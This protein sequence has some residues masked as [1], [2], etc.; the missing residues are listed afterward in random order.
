MDCTRQAPSARYEVP[1]KNTE[2]V[3]CPFSLG[4]SHPGSWHGSSTLQEDPL[5]TEPPG[6][7]Y[8]YSRSSLV[9]HFMLSTLFSVYTSILTS[10]SRQ[11]FFPPCIHMC[12]L[13]TFE[14]YFCFVFRPSILLLVRIY[15][16]EN[17]LKVILDIYLKNFDIYPLNILIRIFSH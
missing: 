6:K 5:T 17:Y 10:Q 2:L 8:T 9:A 12:L 7:P 4:S 1:G 3:S 14:L 16:Q 11:P 15:W 13:S